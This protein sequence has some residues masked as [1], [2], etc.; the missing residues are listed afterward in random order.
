MN[1]F[2]SILITIMWSAVPYR[3]DGYEVKLGTNRMFVVTNE[4]IANVDWNIPYWVYVTAISNGLP[5]SN[6]AVANWTFVGCSTNLKSWT[7]NRPI[8]ASQLYL[9]YLENK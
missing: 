5:V 2:L 4:H 6:P 8:N 9:K 7:T 1:L 3:V